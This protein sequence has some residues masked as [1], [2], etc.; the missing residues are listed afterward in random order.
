MVRNMTCLLNP[1]HPGS[2]PLRRPLL[3]VA[4]VERYRAL[5]VAAKVVK[6]LDLVDPDDPVLTGEG[7]LNGTEL[8]AFCGQSRVTDTVLCLSSGEERI[9][10]VVRH[11]VPM[12]LLAVP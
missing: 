3:L 12:T 1:Q 4:L 2:L 10:V 11:L 6:I 5:V 9:V 7:L 8:R